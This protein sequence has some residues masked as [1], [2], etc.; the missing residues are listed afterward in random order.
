VAFSLL[1]IAP[2]TE[3]RNWKLESRKDCRS[4]PGKPSVAIADVIAGGLSIFVRYAVAFLITDAL[5]T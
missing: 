2:R 1:P 4:L 5:V 3:I